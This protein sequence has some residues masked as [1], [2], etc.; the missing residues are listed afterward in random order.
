MKEYELKYSGEGERKIDQCEYLCSQSQWKRN[1]KLLCKTKTQVFKEIN[2]KKEKEDL[3]NQKLFKENQT[4]KSCKR[5]NLNPFYVNSLTLQLSSAQNFFKTEG[6]S[7]CKKVLAQH[8]WIQHKHYPSDK[9]EYSK[10]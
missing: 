6:F 10:K 5:I 9:L 2:W 8:G 4:M 7:L 1:L 3:G